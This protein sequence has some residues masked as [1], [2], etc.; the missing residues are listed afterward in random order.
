MK[1]VEKYERYC[2]QSTKA[3]APRLTC[4]RFCVGLQYAGDFDEITDQISQYNAYISMLLR[5][6]ARLIESARIGLLLVPLT[7]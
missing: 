6:T 5:T 7:V 2:A 1:S 3:A 4:I